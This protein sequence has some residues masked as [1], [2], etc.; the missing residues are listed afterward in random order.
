VA[1]DRN[2]FLAALRGSEMLAR[3]ERLVRVRDEGDGAWE[4]LAQNSVLTHLTSA[5]KTQLQ[6]YL[7]PCLGGDNEV[8]WRAG[9]V[10][11]RAYLVDDAVVTLRC[12]EGELKPFTCGAFVGEVDALRATGPSPSSARVTQTGKMFAIDQPD[13]VRFF[14]DNPGVYLSFLGTRFVE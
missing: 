14:E 8:L 11:K 2:D 12:P 7:V 9:D 4:L 10:P 5:Q 1:L 6:T 3:L 13:L